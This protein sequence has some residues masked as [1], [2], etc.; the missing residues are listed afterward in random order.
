MVI[1]GSKRFFP[2][3]KMPKM[4]LVSMQ[5]PIQC[6]PFYLGGW[7]VGEGVKGLGD[8]VDHL[9]P[10]SA[11]FKN[12]WIYTSTPPICLHGVDRYNFIV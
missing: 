2:L 12:K 5:P 6:V 10:F 11:K 3:S 7:G 9:P 4:A 8:G 1:N